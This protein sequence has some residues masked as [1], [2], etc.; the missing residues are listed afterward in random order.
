MSSRVCVLIV[1]SSC[2]VIWAG[3]S[4]I[5]IGRCPVTWCTVWRGTPQDCVDHMRLS[6]MVPASIR[7]SN[8]ARW[9]PPWTVSRENWNTALRSS[10]SGVATDVLLF[11]RIGAP[12]VHRYRVFARCRTHSA[13]RDKRRGRSLASQMPSEVPGRIRSREP[14]HSSPPSTSR[15]LSLASASVAAVTSEA[16][17]HAVICS[18]GYGRRAASFPLDLSLPRFAAL[19]A[20]TEPCLTRMRMHEY[21]TPASPASFTSPSVCLNLDTLSSD[22]SAGPGDVSSHPI[23][24]SDVWTKSGDRDQ[25]LSGDDAPHSVH[26]DLVTPTSPPA[27]AR[28]QQFIQSCLPATAPVTLS[29][30]SYTPISPNRVRSDCTPGMVDGGLLF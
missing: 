27:P 2:S 17:T 11:S 16:S 25:E 29:A 20:R 21:D 22:G 23:T 12:L 1:G 26:V 7:G 10:A 24:I 3:M 14:I 6:H 9:F 5:F 15:R 8:L 13:F 4:L 28:V 19:E 18:H 30:T